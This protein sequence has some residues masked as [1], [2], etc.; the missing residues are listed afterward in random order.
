MFVIK[1]L[2]IKRNQTNWLRNC[3][4][5]QLKLSDLLEAGLCYQYV[6][7]KTAQVK[8]ISFGRRHISL[9]HLSRCMTF[10]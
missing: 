9:T 6:V 1:I 5:T 3:C 7:A 2:I 10:F 8:F 4:E